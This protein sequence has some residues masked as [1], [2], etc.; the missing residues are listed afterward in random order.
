MSALPWHDVSPGRG[1]LPPRA[2]YARSDA[3][4]LSL[5]G[6]WASRLSPTADAE[7]ESF[8]APD[9]DAGDRGTVAVPGHW[10]LQGKANGGA[11]EGR[12]GGSSGDSSGGEYGGPVHTNVRYPFPVDAPRVPT[13][14]P[15]GDRLRRFDLPADRTAS[16]GA[17][18]RPAEDTEWAR[19]GQTGAGCSSGALDAA[20][21]RGEPVPGDTL[22]L[23]LDRAQHGIGSQSCGPGV[24]P[25][26]RLYAAP[27]AFLLAFT[28]LD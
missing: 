24:L 11:V 9:F 7:D 10:V 26:Y 19:A 22:W 28:P 17:V 15:T 18:L 2:R 6:D 14:N 4:V 5:N 21:H 1:T 25:E 13:E 20:A 16:G 8:A 3:P 12:H 27:V 23:H